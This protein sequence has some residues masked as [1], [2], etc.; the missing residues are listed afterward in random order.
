MKGCQSYSPAL[1]KTDTEVLKM[2]F[3][4]EKSCTFADRNLQKFGLDSF[5][6]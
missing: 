2:L 4:E 6:F 1:T 3:S 5:V